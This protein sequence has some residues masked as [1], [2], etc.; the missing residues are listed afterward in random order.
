MHES[1]WAALLSSGHEWCQ[2]TNAT[3]AVMSSILPPRGNTRLSSESS[4]GSPCRADSSAHGVRAPSS[5]ATPCARSTSVRASASASDA[6]GA[7]PP[8]DVRTRAAFATSA[9]SES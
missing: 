6:P 5:R 1:W 8:P 9:M 3:T 4:V 7:P 2:T